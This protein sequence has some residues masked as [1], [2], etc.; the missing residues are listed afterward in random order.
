VRRALA[1]FCLAALSLPAAVAAAGAGVR[2]AADESAYPTIRVTIVT[3]KSASQP[4]LLRENGS[5]VAAD[6]QNLGRGANVVIA[7][8]RS[9]SMAGPPLANAT[10]AVRSFIAHKAADTSVEV[11]AFGSRAVELTGMSRPTIDAEQALSTVE[12]DRRAG[13]ALWDAVLVASRSLS[14]QQYGGR[15][16]VL[17]TDGSDT[18][19]IATLDEAI[20][21]ARK[22]GVTVYP[23]GIESSQF[24]PDALERL[25]RETGGS[26]HPASSTSSLGNVYA[27]VARELERTWR[28]SYPTAGRPGDKLT[29]DVSAAS[30]GAA[31]TTL[32]LPAS[33]DAPATDKPSSFVPSIAYSN[34]IGTLFIMLAVAVA[35]LAA[36][37]LVFAATSGKRLRRRIDPHVGR[38]KAKKKA[39][40][41]ERLSAADGLL[42]AT[43]NAFSRFTIL[44][45]LQRLLERADLPLRA[46]EL[47]YMCLGSGF[48]LTL[49][50][51]LFRLPTLIWPA[52]LLFGGCIP[53]VFVAFKARRRL[54]AIEDSLPD[55]LIT[56]AASLKAGHSFR[57]GIQAATDEDQGPVTKELKRVLTETS[58]GRPM[59]HALQEM[60]DR[61]GSKDLQ[62]VITA[63]TIQRQVG[64]SLAGIF[65]LVSDTIRARQQFQRKVRGL[66]AMGR[67]SSYTLMALPFFIGFLLMLVNPSYMSPLYTTSTGHLLIAIG[68]VMMA[69]GSVILNKITSF[70]G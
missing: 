13:T 28:L 17:L 22:A 62:F 23:I 51:M 6:A 64:G 39:T 54:A 37:A 58:L 11:L 61:V 41:R 16:L 4:P 56:L 68:F 29:L 20:T 24:S 9:Q 59:D 27:A 8:D 43:E 21:A 48:A 34:G 42:D 32:Q 18:S 70:K 50:F 65:D 14:A 46:A 66:T 2:I 49:L 67:M 19:S 60:A 69:I 12:V 55:L 63:V 26:Y 53:V 1:L 45:K 35:T 47:F 10:T 15:V 33:L 36:F 5:P 40:A 25:A 3:S 30:L 44:A 57:Q 52:A 38:G 31:E 7:I